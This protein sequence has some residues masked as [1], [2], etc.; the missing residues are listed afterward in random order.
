MHRNNRKWISLMLI[1][2]LL[3]SCQFLPLPSLGTSAANVSSE[4]ELNIA[5][6]RDPGTADAQLTAEEYLLPLNI[7]DR[8]VEAETVAPGHSRIV[9]GLAESWQISEDG[10]VYTFQLRQGVLFHNGEELTSDDVLFSFDRMLDPATQALNSDFLNMIEGA[11]ARLDGRVD[12]TRGLQELGRYTIAITLSAPFAPFLPGLA[13]P[14]CSIYNRKAT[15]AAGRDF[16]AQPVGTGPFRL[17]RWH[18]DYKIVLSAFDAYYQGPPSLERLIIHILPDVETQRMQFETGKLDIYDLDLNRSQIPYFR[19]HPLYGDWIISAPRVGTYFLVLNQAL[20]PLDQP[21]LRQAVNLAIDRELLLEKFFYNTGTPA[22]GLLAPGL[23]GYNDNLA[24]FAYDP[25]WARELV[26]SSGLAKPKLSIWQPATS[27]NS[28][29]INE[30]L[31]A[32][33]QEVGFEVRIE[34]VDTAAWISA[35]RQSDRVPLY[36]TNWSAD[37]NDPDNFL[38][39]YFAAENSRQRSLNLF[40]P[41]IEEL[42]QQGR[43][44]TDPAQRYAAYQE[45]ERIAIYEQFALVPLFHLDHLFVV[46]PKVNGFQVAWNGWSDMNYYRISKE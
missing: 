44:L 35:R 3:A 43:S 30:A 34:Q 22:R 46:H 15:E 23:L 36:Y 41:R 18:F 26:R 24:G 21:S 40:D 20:A 29:Q 32:M 19:D 28:L 37:V 14:A 45:A 6:S 8:L 33:L 39:T 38:S 13:T 11:E 5:L 25:D 27:S 4:R 7:F 17:E 12:Y 16:G 31:Q 10:L 2:S 1:C 42:L 9:P